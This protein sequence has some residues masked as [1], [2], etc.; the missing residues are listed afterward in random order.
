[1]HKSISWLVVFIGIVSRVIPHVPDFTPMTVFVFFLA[2]CSGW[3]YCEEGGLPLRTLFASRRGCGNLVCVALMLVVSDL[4]VSFVYG[5]A[6]FGSWSIFTYSMY[7]AII[8]YAILSKAKN[9]FIL[10]N[11]V[12]AFLF[13]LWTNFG[14]FVMTEMYPHTLSGFVAC[15]AAALPFL[16]Y[17]LLGAVV[18]SGMLSFIES[19]GCCRGARG[20]II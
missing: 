17:S 3:R 6:P 5:N 4:L 13:W 16:G 18:W 14:T 10:V 9:K 20:T 7:A 15:Y 11:G 8:V 1:M 2:Q 12:L 19:V